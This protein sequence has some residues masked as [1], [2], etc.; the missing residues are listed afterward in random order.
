MKE[1]LNFTKVNDK[2]DVIL[3]GGEEK[4]KMSK[5]IRSLKTNMLTLDDYDS[6][7]EIILKY[8]ILYIKTFNLC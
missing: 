2:I 8:N 5:A 4:Y 1:F 7:S 3:Y 6:V